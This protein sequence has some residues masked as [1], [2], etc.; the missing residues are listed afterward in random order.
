MDR[1]IP[2]VVDPN[3]KHQ[4]WLPCCRERGAPSPTLTPAMRVPRERINPY[5]FLDV[6]MRKLKADDVVVCGN[7]SACVVTFQVAE[8]K[9]GLRLFCNS[10]SASM[11]YDIPAAIGAAFATEGRVICLAGD[12]SSMFNLQELQTIRHHNLNIKVFILSNEGYLSMRTT[13]KNF[14]K[15]NYVGEGPRSG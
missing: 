14:F 12:G 10:G 11:G 5:V 15:G 2:A 1:Q 7:G 4:S 6:L 13:Q 9:R 3:A 8:I